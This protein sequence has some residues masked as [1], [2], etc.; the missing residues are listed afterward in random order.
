MAAGEYVEKYISICSDGTG[1]E[2]GL[3]TVTL[4]TSYGLRCQ[5]PLM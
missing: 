5:F 3:F 2:N 4:E 1:E